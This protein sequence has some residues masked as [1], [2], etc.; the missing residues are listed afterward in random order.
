MKLKLLKFNISNKML[1]TLYH[2]QYI[3]STQFEILLN[4]MEKKRIKVDIKIK[5]WYNESVVYMGDVYMK[6]VMK[7]SMEE[8]FKKIK[9]QFENIIQEEKTKCEKIDKEYLERCEI[10]EK[11]LSNGKLKKEEIKNRKKELTQNL[12]DKVEIAL[13]NEFDSKSNE[14]NEEKK[15]I[16]TK[17]NQ[18]NNELY[19]LTNKYNQDIKN[20]EEKSIA[21]KKELKSK[22]TEN[23]T[24]KLKKEYIIIPDDKK[25]E[26]IKYIKL[27]M[28]P[29]DVMSELQ[30]AKANETME[31]ILL[32]KI[33]ISEN[34]N[35]VSVG[36]EY[37]KNVNEKISLKKEL[38]IKIDEIN[39]EIEQLEKDYENNKKQINKYNT[40]D[41][42]ER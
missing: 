11:A 12:Y 22:L 25:E 27:G 10:I 8:E 39:K 21:D 33:F 31:T 37:E 41:K 1:T 23:E 42:L 40:K 2:N 3:M 7:K 14:L 17:I 9:S 13:K 24:K 28:I 29:F 32:E 4:L 6:D 5:M 16:I 30:I 34:D 26:I 20:I 19:Q 35:K 15:S 18:I 38:L 36:R